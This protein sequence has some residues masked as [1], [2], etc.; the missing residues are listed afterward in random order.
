LHV[1]KAALAASLV[2]GIQTVR[3]AMHGTRIDVLVEG[4]SLAGPRL[5]ERVPEGFCL[6]DRLGVSD[7]DGT[8]ST[9]L[10]QVTRIE[11]LIIMVGRALRPS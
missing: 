5:G 6:R 3:Q 1:Q 9:N 2:D 11:L 10:R 8:T 7:L 4:V